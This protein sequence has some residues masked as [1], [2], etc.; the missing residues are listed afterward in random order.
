VSSRDIATAVWAELAAIEPARSCCRAAERAGLGQDAAG[1]ARN[2]AIGR[3]AVRL[4]DRAG[5][6]AQTETHAGWAHEAVHCRV[7]FVRGALLADGSLS[8]GE[9][10][11]HLELLVDREALDAAAKLVASLGFPAGGRVRRGKGVLTWKGTET[12]VG[13]LRRLGATAST[14]ELESRLVGRAVR[15]HMNRVVNAEQANLRRAVAAARRQ[16]DEI[17]L[18]NADGSIERLPRHVRRVADARRRAPEAT[19]SELA[20]TLDLSRSQVQRALQQ[21]GTAAL[22]RGAAQDESRA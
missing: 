11:M 17:E 13:M 6:N 21:I 12:I 10:G 15:G 18:I 3:L 8:V 5:A 19:L 2:P 20:A 16:L 7:S 14:L 9:H 4:E 1:R 22:H